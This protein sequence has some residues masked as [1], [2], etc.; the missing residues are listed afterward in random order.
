MSSIGL[1]HA[2]VLV[3]AAMAI[4]ACNSS[5]GDLAG[6]EG[7]GTDGSA[8]TSTV[9]GTATTASGGVGTLGSSD[10]G[11]ADTSDS[12]STASSSSDSADTSS[13]GDASTSGSSTRGSST[14]NS[15]TSG[16][17]T[18]GSSTGDSGTDDTGTSDSSTG[19]TGSGITSTPCQTG[20]GWTLWR[21]SW[22]PNSA[23]YANVDA[24]DNGCEYSLANQACSLSGEP[25]DYANFGPGVVF[26]SSADY[27]RVRFSVQGLSFSNATLYLD[28]HADGGGIPHGMFSSPIYGTY[29]LVPSVP[30]SQHKTYTID[31]TP[32]LSPSDAPSLTAV[33]LESMPIGLAASFMELCVE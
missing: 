11:G 6:D 12:G 1:Q 8:S 18:S 9:G 27:F 5:G 33:T 10:S 15:S 19:G 20:P 24:W 4:P 25:H 31:W 22:E 7:G 2:L 30:I 21:L 26:N 3:V 13:S 17:S 23:G 28:A 32:Y 16:S 29:D 14:D